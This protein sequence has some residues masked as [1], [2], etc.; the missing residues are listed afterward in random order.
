[1]DPEAYPRGVEGKFLIWRR[2]IFDVIP[3]EA[4]IQCLS[5]FLDSRFRG[6]D[7]SF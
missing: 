7:V 6:S 1:M 4:G 2:E 5:S 3:A